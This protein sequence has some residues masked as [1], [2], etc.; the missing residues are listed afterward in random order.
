MNVI[1]IPA[2]NPLKELV[3]L[4]DRLVSQN[5]S[6]VVVDDGSDFEFREVFNDLCE[7][8]VVLR[9]DIN[10]GKG[11]A[12]KK[13]LN[14][15]SQNTPEAEFIVTMDADGQH[16]ISDMK[17]VLEKVKIE[18]NALVLGKRNFDKEIPFRSKFGNVLTGFIFRKL[19]KTSISDTQTGLRAFSIKYAIDFQNITGSRYEYEMNMLLYAAKRNIPIVEEDIETIYHDSTNSCSHFRKVKDSYIIYREI[20]KSALL[21]KR[22]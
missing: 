13:A 16:K 22:Y 5:Y 14:Y 12:L 15:I 21:D 9:H 11:E 20:F 4:T 10:L 2:Y 1:I 18:K 8:V 17:K 3:K 7:E 19:S 6:I